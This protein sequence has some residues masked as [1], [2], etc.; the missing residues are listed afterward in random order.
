MSGPRVALANSTNS[1][2]SNLHPTSN[3]FISKLSSRKSPPTCTVSLANVNANGLSC[4]NISS[5]SSSTLSTTNLIPFPSSPTDAADTLISQ[6]DRTCLDLLRSSPD[7]PSPPRIRASAVVGI[8]QERRKRATLRLI[9]P[10]IRSRASD[11]RSKTELPCQPPRKR[12]RLHRTP[13]CSSFSNSSDLRFLALV[14]RSI[15]GGVLKRLEEGS[16]SEDTERSILE[17]QDRLL[18]SRLRAHLLARGFKE[19]DVVDLD[20]EVSAEDSAMDID[21][22]LEHT[23]FVSADMDVDV[24]TLSIHNHSSISSPGSRRRSLSPLPDSPL[25]PTHLVA[26]L[27]FR[28]GARRGVSSTLSS[29]RSGIASK[30]IRSSSPLAVVEPLVGW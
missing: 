15:A 6:S 21:S 22:D 2:R 10:A 9:Q 19:K 30:R 12:P 7:A 26:A 17:M 4:I 11:C 27:I 5:P 16:W 1:S 29:A 18:A 23:P 3:R 25:S 24:E 14:Q 8:T 28:N 13:K 20:S